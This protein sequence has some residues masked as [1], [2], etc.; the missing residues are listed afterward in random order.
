VSQTQQSRER[1]YPGVDVNQQSR[2][3][4]AFSRLLYS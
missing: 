1:T 2:H 3:S 4:T